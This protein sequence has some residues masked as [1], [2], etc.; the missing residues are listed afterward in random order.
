MK[1]LLIFLVLIGSSGMI[2]PQ[3]FGAYVDF[4]NGKDRIAINNDHIV[5]FKL[6]WGTGEFS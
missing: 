5:D 3:T 2:I 1:C 4:E 6:D